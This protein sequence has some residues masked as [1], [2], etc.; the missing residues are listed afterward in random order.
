TINTGFAELTPSSLLYCPVT[1][2]G[3]MLGVVALGT[4][5]HLTENDRNAVERLV[6][7]LG[8]ALH[9]IKQYANLQLLAE[10]LRERGE[11]IQLKNNQLEAASRMKSEFLANMSHELRTPLNAIIGFAE[12]L[13]DGLVGDL[14]AQQRECVQDI[15]ES[16]LHLLALINDI[17]D[18]SKIEAG[19][20]DVELA[21]ENPIAV[22]ES[23]LAIVR[24]KAMTQR[25]RLLSQ[26]PDDL[27]LLELDV[28]KVK[29]IVFNLLSNAV[30][31][32]DEGGDVSIGLERMSRAEVQGV[33]A[34]TQGRVFAPESFAYDEYLGIRVVDT[35]IGIAHADLERLFEP[36]TQVDS[37]LSRKHTGTGLGLAMVRRL[38]ELLDGA[39][40]VFSTEGVG[41][42]FSVWLPW[43]RSPEPTL[44]ELIGVT[45]V[46]RR[47]P[48]VLV[49]EDRVQD[50]QLLRMQLIDAG[51]RVGL[52]PSAEG[53]LQQ[54]AQERPDA[55]VLDIIL[56][57]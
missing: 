41:S 11:E 16:G 28:R 32:T 36:F 17:L 49:I 1:Y 4:T 39:M 54:M 51:F 55:I 12:I 6:A 27:G 18:L 29:Q 24:E 47:S 42:S 35:G 37:A 50:A 53:A 34:Q 15:H 19:R 20:L 30:K 48:L 22:I 23:G 14:S 21:S 57:G 38:V 40:A 31:F 44:P 7:Q 3:Q 2:R 46:Q 43:I 5:T 8:A 45:L 9:N 26:W 13:K 56:P 25:V 10:E 52:T 33:L